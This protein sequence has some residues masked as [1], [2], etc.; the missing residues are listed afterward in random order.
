MA[1]IRGALPAVV[2][3]VLILAVAMVGLLATRAATSTADR[4]HRDDR[5]RLET[6]LSGLGD[7]YI[8]FTFKEEFD[9]ASSGPWSLHAG[10]SG[11]TGR[12]RRFVQNSPLT[13]Y[14]AALVDLAGNPLN[15][16]APSTGLPSPTDPGFAPLKA[17]LL[18][19]KPGLSS[20]MSVHALSLVAYGVPVMI[21]NKPKAILVAFSRLDTSQ[22]QQYVATLHY[23]RTGYTALVD[24]NGTVVV[25][26]NPAMIG[27]RLPT[28]PALTA[29]LKGQTGFG[30]YQDPSAGGL[31]A[32][33]HPL[34]FAGWGG[35]TAQSSAEFFGPIHRR[36][37][38]VEAALA[39]LLV[40]AAALIAV[41]SHRRHTALS[42]E[43]HTITALWEARERFRLAFE[44]SPVG[45]ALLSIDDEANGRMVQVNRSLADLTGIE[46][47]ELEQLTLQAITHPDDRSANAAR[48]SEVIEGVIPS[49]EL[50]MRFVHADGHPIWV[51]FHGSVVRSPEGTPLYGLAQVQDVTGRKQAEERLAHLALHDPLTGLANRSLL[52][53]RIAQALAGSARRSTKVGVLYVDLDRFKAVNDSLGHAIGDEVLIT[54]GQRITD[55]I[56]PVDTAARIGGDEFV[57][58]CPDLGSAEDAIAIAARVES[59]IR[60]PLVVEGHQVT[61][62]ASVGISFGGGVECY[63]EML[64]RDADSA[65]YNVKQQARN[66]QEPAA[67]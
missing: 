64:L 22:L 5:Q 32:A 66:A 36:G 10:D 35:I 25:S 13:G 34:S 60:Q 23:G 41:H 67:Q 31:V 15:A 44:E 57:V 3:F 45:M 30:A 63:A 47:A 43:V 39:L 38:E 28:S 8:L 1:R 29:V 17:A 52:M 65:M 51:L 21:D 2:S 12:L 20:V 49:Y 9:F 18:G 42:R 56:R 16:W 59:S 19:G 40:L 53:D 58:V 11:D 50:E 6:T 61:V 33:Y 24:G 54:T 4:T 37:F 48:A 26:A 46:P 62:E 27:R 7:Q 55:A 14:G